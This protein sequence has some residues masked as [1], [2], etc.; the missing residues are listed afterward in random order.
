M[1]P[2]QKQIIEVS[3]D[4]FAKKGFHATS[5]QEIVDKAEVAKGTF[6]TYFQSKEDLILSMYDYY[7]GYVM[8]KMKEAEDNQSDARKALENEL[9]IFFHILLKHKSL[10]MMML[11]D[12]VP[13]GKDME[14]LVM[15]TRQQSFEWV[16]KHIRAIYGEGIE[17]YENDASILFEG[18]FKEYANWLVVAE[19]AVNIKKLPQFILNILDTICHHLMQSDEEPVITHLPELFQQESILINKMKQMIHSVVIEDQ[20]KALEA[21]EVIEAELQKNN[22]Q[23]LIIESMLIHLRKYDVLENDIEQLEKILDL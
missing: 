14:V 12:Q 4:L 15:R 13:L 11:R 21:I 5:V 2:K 6:Y 1:H 18:I 8:E 22:R 10:I 17:R 20:Q 3:I 16:K 9:N 7:F 23:M 19:E